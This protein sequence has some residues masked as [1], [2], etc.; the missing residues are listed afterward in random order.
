MTDLHKQNLEEIKDVNLTLDEMAAAI[1]DAKL[2]KW[3]RERTKEYWESLEGVR[4]KVQLT[5]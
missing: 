1:A 4:E 2:K 5:K 3:F